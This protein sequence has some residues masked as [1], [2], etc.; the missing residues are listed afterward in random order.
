MP[1][2]VIS[3]ASFDFVQFA[4]HPANIL[5]ISANSKMDIFVIYDKYGKKFRHPNI[6]G[7]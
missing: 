4:T 3:H 7:K 6:L 2:N 1:Q 5:D